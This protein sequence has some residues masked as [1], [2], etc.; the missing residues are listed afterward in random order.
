MK[1]KKVKLEP[2]LEK[3]VCDCGGDI[4]YVDSQ[5]KIDNT[6]IISKITHHKTK[7]YIYNVINVEKSLKV[8]FIC[9]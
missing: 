7:K 5:Y 9:H 1:K 3:I 6:S 8:S 2:Y 4:R